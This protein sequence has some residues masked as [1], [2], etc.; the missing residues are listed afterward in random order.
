[1]DNFL[2]E[3]LM[4]W[5]NLQEFCDKVITVI[6]PYHSAAILLFFNTNTHD[7]NEAERRK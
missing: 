5:S 4:G 2:I 7:Q 6:D 3:N 1:M